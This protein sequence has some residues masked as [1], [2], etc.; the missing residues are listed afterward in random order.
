VTSEEHTEPRER[1]TAAMEDTADNLA[2]AAKK[3]NL[4]AEAARDQRS[5]QRLRALSDAVM[6]QV[7][8]IRKRVSR[9]RERDTE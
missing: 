7:E 8:A 4:S 3:L 5:K 9:L 2:D 6:A 1:T